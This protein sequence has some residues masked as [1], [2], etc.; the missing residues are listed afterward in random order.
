VPRS[1]KSENSVIKL[2]LLRLRGRYDV[3]WHTGHKLPE[4]CKVEILLFSLPYT[5][6]YVGK[7]DWYGRHVELLGER[8][9]DVFEFVWVVSVEYRL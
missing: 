1:G 3:V 9:M 2:P 5:G 6:W 4:I 7:N 8:H